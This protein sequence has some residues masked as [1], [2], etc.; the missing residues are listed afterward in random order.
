MRCEIAPEASPWAR[1]LERG[2][3]SAGSRAPA[4]CACDV[5]SLPCPLQRTRAE[6]VAS[7]ERGWCCP[8]RGT[9]RGKNRA[10]APAARP[11]PAHGERSTPAG[12]AGGREPGTARDPSAA[13]W[14]GPA[15]AGLRLRPA[16]SRRGFLF[17]FSIPGPETKCVRIR[18]GKGEAVHGPAPLASDTH[19][20][21][22]KKKGRG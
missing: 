14:P 6:L 5:C 17:C 11:A 10:L 13:A 3:V 12:R 15:V 1:P 16:A 20:H 8:A 19:T 22:K 2:A 18:R 7:W 4:A 9:G 21:Q